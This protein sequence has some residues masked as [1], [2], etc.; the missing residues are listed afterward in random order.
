MSHSVMVHNQTL[1]LVLGG[2][3]ELRLRLNMSPEIVLDPIRRLLCD[4]RIKLPNHQHV[5]GG[6]TAPS[7]LASLD[8][9]VSLWLFGRGKKR[10][11]NKKNISDHKQ[12]GLKL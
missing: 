3:T 1:N 11:S 2:D 9:R 8:T 12:F 4:L 6:W 7:Y 5:S 10:F